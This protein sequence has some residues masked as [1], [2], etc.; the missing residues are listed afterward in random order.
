MNRIY[1][2][3]FLI[4]LP[5]QVSAQKEILNN[6]IE[7]VSKTFVAFKSSVENDDKDWPKKFV[8]SSSVVYYAQLLTL[9][10]EAD[11]TQLMEQSHSNILTVLYARYLSKKGDFSTIKN[12]YDL[13]YYL[14]NP[15]FQKQLEGVVVRDIKVSGP[16]A[17]VYTSITE[18]TEYIPYDFILQNNNWK[19]YLL[20]DSESMEKIFS[21]HE[22]KSQYG[23]NKADVIKNIIHVNGWDSTKKNI[24]LPQP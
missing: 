7:L 12:P 13:I 4:Y 10:K 18:K 16:T 8:D 2:L 20:S 3:F 5:F 23:S 11:S 22:F 21:S 14:G 24:W 6:D 15:V 17:I 9:I 19:L 1:L